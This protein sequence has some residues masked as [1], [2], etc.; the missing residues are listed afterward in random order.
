MKSLTQVVEI[1]I[2][3]EDSCVEGLINSSD[4]YRLGLITSR[5]FI[6]QTLDVTAATIREIEK[7]C[8]EEGKTLEYYQGAIDF[9]RLYKS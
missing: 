4:N 7:I 9:Y 1:I 5:E 6:E 2:S 3:F 8:M